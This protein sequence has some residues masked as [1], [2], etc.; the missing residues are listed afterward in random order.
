MGSIC[1]KQGSATLSST[2]RTSRHGLA[3]L[4]AI[5]V[6]FLAAAPA[7][8]ATSTVD[9]G[10]NGALFYNAAADQTNELTIFVDRSGST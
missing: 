2:R 6:T 8:A 5:V 3:A 1:S 4:V 10:G 9:V 7:M